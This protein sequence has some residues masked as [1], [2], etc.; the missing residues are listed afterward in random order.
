MRAEH[1]LAVN[2]GCVWYK[3]L[4]DVVFQFNEIVCQLDDFYHAAHKPSLKFQEDIGMYLPF[5]DD[6]V[7][8]ICQCIFSCQISV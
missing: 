5:S 7:Y 1:D 2:L 8:Q 3:D 6:I 4:P